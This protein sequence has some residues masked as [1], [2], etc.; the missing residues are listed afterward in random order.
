M[1]DVWKLVYIASIQ[2]V[3]KPRKIDHEEQSIPV[4][5]NDGINKFYDDEALWESFTSG[6]ESSFIV[7][8]KTY[9]SRL[10]AY[11]WRITKDENLI[12]DCIQDLFIS[13]RK[14]R[15]QLGRTNSIK[16]YLFK[17]LKRI[18]VS[19]LNKQG[20]FETIESNHYFQLSFS[21]EEILINQQIDHEKKERLKKAIHNL[22]PRKREVIYYFY[23]ENLTYVQIQEIMGLENIKSTRNLLYK[24]LDSLKASLY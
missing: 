8:Y 11:G 24:A 2:T 20:K 4:G 5:H 14:N 1:I 22:S 21:Q 10:Y 6:N 13:L 3:T 19:E 9:F 16:Y 23:F 15:S 18:L 17:C 7:I 12:K